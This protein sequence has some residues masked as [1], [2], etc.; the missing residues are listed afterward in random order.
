MEKNNNTAINQTQVHN[1]KLFIILG[2]AVIT[3]LI[4]VYFSNILIQL[5]YFL[6]LLDENKV[7]IE[8]ESHI[9]KTIKSLCITAMLFFAGIIQIFIF[10]LQ[11]RMKEILYFSLACVAMALREFIFSNVWM[12]LSSFKVETY[13]Q[14]E[15]M[16]MVLIAIFIPLYL[17]QYV[18]RKDL[19]MIQWITIFVSCI[20]GIVILIGPPF[21]YV[22]LLG[23]YQI[24]LVTCILWGTILIFYSLQ[25][26]NKEQLL[27]LYGIT[28][29]SIGCIRDIVTNKNIYDSSIPSEHLSENAMLVFVVAQMLSLFLKNNRLVAETKEAEKR[30]SEENE[31]LEQLNNMKT[32]F[33]GNISH[34]LKTPLTVV[35]SHIQYAR[36]NVMNQKEMANTDKT[37]ELIGSE[38]ENMS[39]LVSQLLDIGSIDEG[40]M[41]INKKNESLVEIIQ[42][43][44][45]N[46]YPYFTRNNNRLYF[47]P[48]G[49]IPSIWCDRNRIMQVLINLLGNASKHTYDG[50]IKILV[51]ADTQHVIIV[52]TDTGEGIDASHIPHLFE[53]YYTRSLK[54]EESSQRLDIGTGLG[55][56]ICKYIAD[57]HQGKIFIESQ[58]GI[59]T[60]VSLMFPIM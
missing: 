5:G 36:E 57:M 18:V 52:I 10:L 49:M 48:E 56:Y 12:H 16:S 59:G 6:N 41:S 21:L 15:Y 53:R 45:D 2:S 43:T 23:Y 14:M 29:F 51:K 25:Q 37:L 44:L 1:Y 58:L 46:Y 32:E 26:T 34:Q 31:A 8:I 11:P 24:V 50:E 9:W 30:L 54:N 20:Y 33:L 42:N 47:K 39:L 55:L 7:S 38:I 35:S 4:L 60:K 3:I 22:K 27:A 40:R 19:R 28:V 13:R 17:G